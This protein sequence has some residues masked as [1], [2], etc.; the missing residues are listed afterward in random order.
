MEA[1]SFFESRQYLTQLSVS[2]SQAF[3][4]EA[5]VL[6]KM[7]EASLD[8]GLSAVKSSGCRHCF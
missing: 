4:N 3:S 8:M 1:L 6:C 2:P 7:S 5:G